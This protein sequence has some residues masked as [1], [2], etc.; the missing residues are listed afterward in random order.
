LIEVLITVGILA[1]ALTV[2]FQGFN[3]MVNSARLSRDIMI[4][5][6]VAEDAGWKIALNNRDS[7]V[8]ALSNPGRA[9][10]EHKEFS[11]DYALEQDARLPEL[12]LLRLTV[13][14]P[15]KRDSAYNIDLYSY[16][17]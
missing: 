1:T 4:G 13:S 14:W 3:Q 15:E 10:L 11:W 7:A 12:K 2:I 6:L 8:E 9:L 16:L 5:C 17:Y